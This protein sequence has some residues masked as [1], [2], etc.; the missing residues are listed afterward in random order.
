LPGCAA[1]GAGFLYGYAAGW[2]ERFGEV[3]VGTYLVAFL[4]VAQRVFGCQQYNGYVAEFFKIV[5]KKAK[6]FIHICFFPL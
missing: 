1:T 2:A 3:G 4:F 5:F 6:N